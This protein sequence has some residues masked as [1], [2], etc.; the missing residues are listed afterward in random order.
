MV[1]VNWFFKITREGYGNDS[2]S[3]R[4][5]YSY[6]STSVFRRQTIYKSTVYRSFGVFFWLSKFWIWIIG[7]V[8][9]SGFP[10][11][12]YLPR[13]KTDSG[14]NHFSSQCF[15]KS[16]YPSNPETQSSH[17]VHGIERV[18]GCAEERDPDKSFLQ[19]HVQSTTFSGL[20]FGFTP[21][22]TEREVMGCSHYSMSRSKTYHLQISVSSKRTEGLPDS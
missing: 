15:C 19:L 20:S 17:L 22:A 10:L 5:F 18:E 13:R 16:C 1:K 3:S 6:S 21:Y 11:E 12:V 2:N 4:G 14:L 7:T 8:P 9:S